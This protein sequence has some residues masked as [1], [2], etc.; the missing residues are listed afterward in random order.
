MTA[1][2]PARS[3]AVPARAAATP[4]PRPSATPDTAPA[5]R[6]FLASTPERL[7]LLAVVAVLVTLG[8][9]LV[10]AQAFRMTSA[11]HD[12]ADAGTAQLLRVQQIDIDLARADATATNAFLVAGQEPAAQ[13]EAYLSALRDASELVARAATAQPAD[14]DVLARLNTVVVEYSGTVEQARANNR[15]NLQ[16]GAQYLRDASAS[17]RG[18]AGPLLDALTSANRSR[19]DAELEAVAQNRQVLFVA[20]ALAAVA[21]LLGSVWLARTTRR[22]VNLGLLAALVLVLVP[23]VGGGTALAGVGQEAERTRA[24]ALRE[25]IDLAQARAAAFDARS[26]ESL[27]LVS[28]GSGAAYEAAWQGD[29]EEVLA[30]VPADLDRAW[31]AYADVHAAVRGQDDQGEWD[32]ARKAATDPDGELAT[33]FVAFDEALTST[34]ETRAGDASS[35]LTRSQPWLPVAGWLSLL[36]GV[37]AAALAW[38]GVG[39]RL[40][41]YR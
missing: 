27:T 23:L 12:R 30:A 39:R 20:G 17:L 24:G 29:A 1:E 40:E 36:A 5:G 35:A 21:L 31:R 15:Q 8:F 16:V 34:L 6:R 13:R 41:E 22:Y 4:A 25:T 11:A 32:A 19:I 7:R 37:A 26:N 3:A 28:R 18:D 9:G 2:T 38:R 14:A 10:A 33:T